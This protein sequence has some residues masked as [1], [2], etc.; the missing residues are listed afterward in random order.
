MQAVL[1]LLRDPV[2]EPIARVVL[3]APCVPVSSDHQLGGLLAGCVLYHDVTVG[4]RVSEAEREPPRLR[5][6]VGLALGPDCGRRSAARVVTLSFLGVVTHAKAS[7]R[8]RT[9]WIFVWM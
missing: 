6:V 8:L 9:S 3:E 4:M 1:L 7:I 2:A 5:L